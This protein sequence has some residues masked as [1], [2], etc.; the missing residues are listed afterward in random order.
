MS[1]PRFPLA[2]T[3]AAA[4]LWLGS[5]P[6]SASAE[7]AGFK[8]YLA[9]EGVATQVTPECWRIER[10]LTCALYGVPPP[11]N[12]SCSAGGAVASASLKFRGRSRRSFIC[13]DEG[14]H[15]WRVLG[16]GDSWRSG[17]F[18]CRHMTAGDGIGAHGRLR[19]RNRDRHGFSV[20]GLG[21]M[22]RF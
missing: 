9:A 12:A 19:C 6:L 3:L 11:R 18:R 15:G 7:P 4:A 5:P 22:R 10:K 8:A 14:F 21:R 20:D 1:L 16:V 2:L 13:V 17:G